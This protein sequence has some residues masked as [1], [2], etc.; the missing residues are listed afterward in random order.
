MA[1]VALAVA[2]P[3]STST[4]AATN[5]FPVINPNSGKCLDVYHSGQA[6]YTNVDI[7][8][9]NG[10]AAQDWHFVKI[11]TSSLGTV[12]QLEN[13][14]SG[15]CLDVY[16]SGTANYTNVDLY[17]CNG[18]TAQGWIPHGSALVSEVNL[19]SCLDVYHSG[20]ANYT[21]VDLF[22][23]NGSGAQA[24]TSYRIP[25]TPPE[26]WFACSINVLTDTC[27]TTTDPINVQFYDP[28]G[29]ALADLSNE[30]SSAGWSAT[31]CFNPLV[32]FDS[33]YGQLYTPDNVLAT[34]VSNAGCGSG[35]RDHARL[36]ASPD[37]HTVYVAASFEQPCSA[38]H[39]VTNFNLGRDNLEAA[40]ESYL[41]DHGASYTADY[42][43]QYASGTLQ[44]VS[45]DG[46]VAIVQ[47]G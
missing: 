17:T 35:L 10:S 4:M 31:S 12:Y 24:W 34:D 26:G 43:Q 20:T 37:D 25:P 21:N 16:H 19:T 40:V 28:G 30:L 11:G 44:G 6:N 7:Y 13:P 22:S 14:N 38:G 2:W 32:R 3:T 9:C 45:Y 29:D 47:V 15:K 23:C 41:I 36:W 27:A 18:S 8:T 1:V 42:V 39:C 46:K 33:G 5:E